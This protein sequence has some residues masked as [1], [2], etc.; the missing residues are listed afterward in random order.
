MKK[1]LF[2]GTPQIAVPALEKIAGLKNYEIVGV[3]VPP[4]KPVGRKQIVQSCPVKQAAQN[5]SLPVQEIPNQKALIDFVQKTECDAAIVIAFGMIFPTEIVIEIPCINVHFSLLPRY[6]GASPVQSA[7]LAGDKT[8][9]ITF[10]RIVPSLDAGPILRQEEYS[11][12]N[13]KTSDVFDSFAH[14]TAE[15]MP[16]FLKQYFA[17]TLLPQKQDESKATFCTKFSKA[18]GEIFPQKETAEQIFRKYRA[19]DIFPG[20][21]LST[22]K[23]N[24]KLT[25]VDLVLQ[26]DGKSIPLPCAQNTTLFLY[27]AQIPG[28][29]EMPITDILRGNPDLLADY[30]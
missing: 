3:G 7:I 2:F 5:M 19:F 17:G 1:I 29:K 4:D 13:Q 21:F 20:I 26:K 15:I 18:D 23:G 8:S 6:R 25:V 12:Q 28:K 24:L 16:V 22:K 10:Q 11:L 30:I 9:G 27:K 14:K